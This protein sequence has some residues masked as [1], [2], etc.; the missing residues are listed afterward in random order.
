[1]ADVPQ[2]SPLVAAYSFPRRVMIMIAVV[3][4]STLYS[5]TLLV[6][7]GMLPQMQ[8]SMAATA[9]EIAW[10]TTFN[11]L[12]TAIVTPMA[13]FLVANFGRRN[14]MLVSVG[15]FTVVT[16]MCGQCESLETLVLWRVLQGAMGAPVVP[17]SNALVLDCFPRRQAG[18]VSS[19]VIAARPAC[20]SAAFTI[21]SVTRSLRMSG[22]S[23]VRRASVSAAESSGMEGVR[24][25]REQS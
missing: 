21:P 4:G 7:S 18:V 3:L 2:D 16:Y 12:A 19:I 14:V 20:M 1:M 25:E 11:I 24:P 22:S 15:G 9:D 10:S 17:I 5:T 8:G 23:T 13:G 6:A